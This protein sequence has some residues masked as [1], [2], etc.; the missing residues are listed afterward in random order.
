MLIIR[1]RY[2]FTAYE[3]ILLFISR[4]NPNLFD[5]EVGLDSKWEILVLSTFVASSV[6]VNFVFR[7]LESK[8]LHKDAM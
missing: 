7:G 3:Y 2:P 1:T 8:G 5:R 4:A 6:V